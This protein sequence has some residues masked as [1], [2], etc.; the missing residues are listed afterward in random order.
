VDESLK[1]KGFLVA[2][3]PLWQ[4]EILLD[5]LSTS[6]NT[7]FLLMRDNNYGQLILYGKKT[8]ETPESKE[9]FKENITNSNH[10]RSVPADKFTPESILEKA[11][12]ISEEL[13]YPNMLK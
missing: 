9:E 10:H 4:T 3:N 6:T 12:D 7:D 5:E 8:P 13:N 1:N 11:F 2:S